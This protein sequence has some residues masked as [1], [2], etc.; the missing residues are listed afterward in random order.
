MNG[1]A[2]PGLIFFLL[3]AA[4]IL[5]IA[6][7]EFKKAFGRLAILCEDHRLDGIPKGFRDLFKNSQLPRIDD[8][9]I[10]AALNSMVE[11]D[12]VNGLADGI[13][14]AEGERHVGNTA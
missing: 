9:H 4:A 8:A 13:V 2:A 10:H 3:G 1:K 7:G 12:S 14:A 6:L 5:S 11:E